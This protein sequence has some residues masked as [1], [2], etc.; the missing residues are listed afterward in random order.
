MFCHAR[1]FRGWY[2]KLTSFD[3]VLLSERTQNNMCMMYNL[4]GGVLDFC[5]KRG[6]L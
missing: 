6:I 4:R 3:K 5:A 2:N 1:F